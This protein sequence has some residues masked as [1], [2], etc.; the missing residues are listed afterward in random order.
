MPEQGAIF[1]V[2]LPDK[3]GAESKVSIILHISKLNYSTRSVEVFIFLFLL[4]GLLD[5]MNQRK[6]HLFFTYLEFHPSGSRGKLSLTSMSCH[7]TL[8]Y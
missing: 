8:A 2:P 5:G 4:K 3:T 6:T 1:G 7:N